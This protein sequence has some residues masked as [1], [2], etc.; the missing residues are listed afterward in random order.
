LSGGG[1]GY[2]LSAL[3]ELRRRR[4]EEAR[5]EL[6]DAGA[7]ARRAE[8]RAA[9]AERS[10]R[11]ATDRRRAAEREQ[12][13]WGAADLEAHGRWV[14]RL[15]HGELDLGGEAARL[16]EE[17]ARGAAREDRHRELLVEAERQ[18]RTLERHRELWEAERR[19]GLLRAEE[20]A[21][22]ELVSARARAPAMVR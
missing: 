21:Q 17:A 13:G 16:R 3:G 4:V 22:E 20:L 5:A 1:R 10:L 18:L 6:A 14:A 9:D 15:R 7:E 8:R 2:P 11:G 19:R 12:E